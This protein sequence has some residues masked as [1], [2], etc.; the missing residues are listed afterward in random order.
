MDFYQ[1]IANYYQYI[2]PLN[3]NQ[4]HFTHRCFPNPDNTVLL[5]AGCGIGLLTLEL[6][7]TFKK[8]VG[9]DLDEN[10]LHQAEETI[11]QLYIP[12]G[13]IEFIHLNMLSI[14]E[15]FG[16]VS[17]DGIICFGNTLV[18]LESREQ[19]IDFF[20]Q[21]R[22]ILKP[23][24]KL[25]FQI[26]N[27]DRILSQK[28]T[29]LPLIE[30]D[31]IRFE[32]SYFFPDQSNKIHFKTKLLIKEKQQIVENCIQLLPLLKTELEKMLKLAGFQYYRCYGDYDLEPF[33]V[34]SD[35]LVMECL[36]GHT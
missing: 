17:F 19:I 28:I 36:A 4:V 35:V 22:K 21:S 24:G 20:N 34:K 30:N 3:V 11:N 13:K 32:R 7:K 14:L 29:S 5:E 12:I 8:V 18:H 26:M 10:M 25:L 9:I 2:F 6:A 23:S 1:S 16:D 33:S 27:Y 15:L 31:R